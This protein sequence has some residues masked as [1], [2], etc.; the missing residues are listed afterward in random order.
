[1][2][3]WEFRVEGRT[4]GERVGWYCKEGEESVCATG[5][6]KSICSLEP[7]QC[8]RQGDTFQVKASFLRDE[9]WKIRP[10][11]ESFTT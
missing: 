3:D 11:G 10:E 4:L 1:L 9:E 8:Q 2:F 7:L 6:R 5:V